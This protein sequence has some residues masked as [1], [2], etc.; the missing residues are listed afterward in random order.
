MTHTFFCSST[1]LHLW[2][3]MMTISLTKNI[4]EAKES[5]SICGHNNVHWHQI[6]RTCV[7]LLSV[8]LDI[9]C[10]RRRE[11]KKSMSWNLK[12]SKEPCTHR[13]VDWLCHVTPREKS[14]SEA[15]VCCPVGPRP[16]HSQPLNCYWA[17][18]A[19]QPHPALPHPC[20]FTW[21]QSSAHCPGHF[22]IVWSQPMQVHPGQDA[23]WT[24]DPWGTPRSPAALAPR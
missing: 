5:R 11:S 9:P 20:W 22:L 3:V 14:F 12:K 15:S 13:T 8:L 6:K 17:Q 4:R 10:L 7:I 16:G 23:E 19:L 21:S 24:W 1:S 2:L 18:P